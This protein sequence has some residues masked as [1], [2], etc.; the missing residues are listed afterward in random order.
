MKLIIQQSQSLQDIV[1]LISFDLLLFDICYISI[2]FFLN[3]HLFLEFHKLILKLVFIHIHFVIST[4]HFVHHI[5]LH[6]HFHHLVLQFVHFIDIY[7]LHRLFL[8]F[9]SPFELFILS[10]TEI[11]IYL[12]LFAVSVVKTACCNIFWWELKFLACCSKAFF[13]FKAIKHF[14]LYI[15]FAEPLDSWDFLRLAFAY[16]SRA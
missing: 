4:K 5:T 14:C 9:H 11:T 10:N 7:F 2:L 1:Y 6:F 8:H 13:F 15:S 12:W 16:A 3:C